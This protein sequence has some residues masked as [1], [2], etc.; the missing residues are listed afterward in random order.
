MVIQMAW[1]DR[2]AKI[3]W[4]Y[5]PNTRGKSPG[6]TWKKKVISAMED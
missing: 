6:R 5:Y 3:V 2:M 1:D 4:K